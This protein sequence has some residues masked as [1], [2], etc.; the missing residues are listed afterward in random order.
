VANEVAPCLSE[1]LNRL[2]TIGTFPENYKTSYITPLIKKVGLDPTDTRSCQWCPSIASG[3]SLNRWSYYLRIGDLQPNCQSAYQ[4]HFL[5]E[6]AVIRVLSDIRQLVD[7]DVAALDLINMSAAFITID[8]DVL[9]RRL[10]FSFG[11][12]GTVFDWLRSYLTGRTRRV[13]CGRALSTSFSVVCGVPR[14]PVLGLI[15]LIMYAVGL[16]HLNTRH[17]LNAYKYADDTRSMA[18]VR[19]QRRPASPTALPCA[20]SASPAGLGPTASSSMPTK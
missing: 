17:N 13:R 4:P 19:K 18:A 1:I 20:S 10:H 14:G 9:L 2:P 6:T 5:S 8:H 16:L 11:L 15:L 3:L 12:D 7:D